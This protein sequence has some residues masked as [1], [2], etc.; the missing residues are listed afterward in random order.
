MPFSNLEQITPI[1]LEIRKLRPCSVLDVGCGLGVYGYLCRIY[2]ELYGD[3]A[4]FLK[5]LKRQKPWEVRID[6]IEGFKDY[7]EFVPRWAYDEITIG[8]AMNALSKIPDK[9]YDVVLA[10]AIL[11][12]FSKT[13]GI[14][15]LNELRRIGRTILLSVPKDWNEQVVPENELETHRSHWTDTE[16]LS[17]GFTRILP[18]PFVW[19]A[20]LDR[21]DE[22]LEAGGEA[23]V[24][25]KKPEFHNNAPRLLFK[26]FPVSSGH[27]TPAY[28]ARMM[29]DDSLRS[30]YTRHETSTYE[31]WA[32][33]NRLGGKALALALVETKG[34]TL[35][36]H[37]LVSEKKYL[38]VMIR[39]LENLARTR[40]LEL[41]SLVP[42]NHERE[43]IA[44]GYAP[45]PHTTSHTQGK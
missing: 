28:L 33:R 13:D 42:G 20:V 27:A 15:F 12:H 18:H 24:L 44:L 8:P 31:K 40:G 16:L 41:V 26:L 43:L 29:G 25:S 32:L 45:P 17:W 19:I 30:F 22:A 9:R 11:E 5:K 10:L 37:D 6:A 23:R 21:E 38:A 34:G 7:L 3:D 35:Y 39:K 4:N 2:L 14:R 36:V 1:L